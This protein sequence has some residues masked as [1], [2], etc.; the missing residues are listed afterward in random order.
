MPAG[1]NCRPACV[2]LYYK[3]SGRNLICLPDRYEQQACWFCCSHPHAVSWL[4]VGKL[5]LL[6]GRLDGHVPRRTLKEGGHILGSSGISGI[7]G[8]DSDVRSDR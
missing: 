1:Q 5:L 3:L 4:Q 7:S 2:V 8:V 6:V